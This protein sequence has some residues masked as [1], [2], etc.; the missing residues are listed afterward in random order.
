MNFELVV[1][2]LTVYRTENDVVQIV[3]GFVIVLNLRVQSPS[4][5]KHT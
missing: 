5:D 3:Y 2:Q 1:F 4:F